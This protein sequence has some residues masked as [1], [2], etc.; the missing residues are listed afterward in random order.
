MLLSRVRR[1][2]YSVSMGMVEMP[3][4]VLVWYAVEK[5]VRTY[6]IIAREI[7]MVKQERGGL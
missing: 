5:V 1:H 2:L 4:I 7:C 6:K 3:G